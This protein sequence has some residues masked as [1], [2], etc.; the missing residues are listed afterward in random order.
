MKLLT[1]LTECDRSKE[2]WT[3]VMVKQAQ[4]Y[5]KNGK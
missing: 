2:K 4:K 5:L 3:N 1:W